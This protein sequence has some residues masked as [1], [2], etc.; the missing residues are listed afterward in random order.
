M[1]RIPAGL[2][3]LQGMLQQHSWSED[4]KQDR[5]DQRNLRLIDLGQKATCWQP[6][7][8]FETA[9]KLFYFS[10]L[11]YEYR[12]VQSSRL[13]AVQIDSIVAC[14]SACLHT[15][16]SSMLGSLIHPLLQ[17]EPQLGLMT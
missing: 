14:L 11:V 9:V 12:E 13:P 6:L 1:D 8:C 17:L 3:D 7:F 5:L 2:L 16:R 15:A 4:E 10:A